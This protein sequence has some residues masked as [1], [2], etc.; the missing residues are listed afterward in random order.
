MWS[1]HLLTHYS[2]QHLQTA[3]DCMYDQTLALECISDRV[4]DD[5]SELVARVLM[6]SQLQSYLHVLADLEWDFTAADLA[7]R[8]PHPS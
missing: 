3:L 2:V 8:A 7:W 5:L 1:N 6:D 4:P